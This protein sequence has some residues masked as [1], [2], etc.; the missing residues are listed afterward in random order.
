LDAVSEKL[1]RGLA[2]AAADAGQPLALNRVGSM[3][4][5]FFTDIPVRNF[6]DAKTSNLE[7]F[8]TYYQGMRER[9]IDLAPSQY[10]ALFV[11]AA[12]TGEQ[13]EATVAAAA[14]ALANLS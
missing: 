11:S 4:G 13:V 9:G 1:A 2:E 5:L 6:A 7:K 14:A 8:A 12:H 3:L 10:E